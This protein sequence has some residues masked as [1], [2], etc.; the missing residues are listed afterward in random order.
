MDLAT[1][2][3]DILPLLGLFPPQRRGP[4]NYNLQGRSIR[5]DG[6]NLDDFK[7]IRSSNIQ[8]N[9]ALQLM[10]IG[11]CTAQPLFTADISTAMTAMQ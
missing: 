1:P 9:T 2:S 6:A 5:L 3:E 8:A 4:P 11:A 7:L 10:L